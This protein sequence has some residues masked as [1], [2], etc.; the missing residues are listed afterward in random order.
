MKA[1][2]ISGTATGCSLSISPNAWK[3]AVDVAPF[4]MPG[5]YAERRL[6]FLAAD[7]LGL[8]SAPS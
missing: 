6:K 8:G 4:N 1:E 5:Q 7:E 2:S 3:I